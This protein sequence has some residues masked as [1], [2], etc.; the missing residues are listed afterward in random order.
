[1]TRK[2]WLAAV[3]SLVL[4]L[5]ILAMGGAYLVTSL[6]REATAVQVDIQDPDLIKAGEY[7]A[8]AADCMACHTVP[9]DRPMAGGVAL[10]TPLGAIYSTNITPDK[11]TGIG[12]YTYADFKNAVQYGVR[13]DNTPLYPAMPYP[14]YVIMPDKD[15]Q[16]LY[17][18]FMSAVEP[19]A[20]ENVQT[21]MPWPLSIRWSVSWWQ[22][23]YAPKRDFT[24]PPDSSEQIARGAYLVEGPGHCGTCHTPRGLG[25]QEK[26]MSLADGDEYLSGAI[27][28]GWRAKSLRGEAR[29]LGA[30]DE[31][32]IAQFLKTGRTEHTVAFG[33]MASTVENSTSFFTDE[34]AAAVAAYLKQLPPASQ[35]ETRLPIKQD[36]TT[37]KLR[38]GTHESRGA[39]V[40]MQQCAACHGVDGGGNKTRVA[41]PLDKNSAIYADTAHSIIQIVLEGGACPILMAHR[42]LQ[43]CPV[44]P[45]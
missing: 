10:N 31:K 42:K 29:G 39:A 21:T 43:P 7:V 27:I 41:P 5:A 6:R 16:A 25:Y 2:S 28:E 3:I 14:S 34:D 19:V 35:Q 8:Q 32:A 13:K 44:L 33:A 24:P 45:I 9:G 23:F 11:Q 38:D 18:Y 37:D 40:Y 20:K 22:W 36:T 17:A 15:I 4:A 1:M 12:D 30:W 26:A